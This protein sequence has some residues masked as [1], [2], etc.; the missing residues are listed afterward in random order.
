MAFVV[1][2]SS[3]VCNGALCTWTYLTICVD[4][5]MML[6]V[7]CMSRN[8]DILLKARAKLFFFKCI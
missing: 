1:V 2:R 3:H 5:F 6:V 8:S 4:V 7:L